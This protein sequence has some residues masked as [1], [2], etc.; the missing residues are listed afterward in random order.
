VI[1]VS[2]LTGDGIRGSLFTHPDG[3]MIRP[4]LVLLDVPCSNTALGH[5][6][7]ENV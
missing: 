5:I 1:G 4:D 3:R 7:L 2:G 6:I